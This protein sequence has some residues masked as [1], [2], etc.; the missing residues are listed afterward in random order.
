VQGAQRRDCAPYKSRR[1]RGDERI[2]QFASNTPTIVRSRLGKVFAHDEVAAI[3]V[4]A[5]AL[6]EHA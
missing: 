6:R 2:G 4:A 1:L 3:A 5:R